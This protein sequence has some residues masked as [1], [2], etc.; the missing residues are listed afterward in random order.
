[1]IYIWSAYLTIPLWKASN[2]YEGKKIWPILVKLSTVF[3]LAY[4]PLEEIIWYFRRGT[5][6]PWWL[7]KDFI[8][9]HEEL[10][11]FYELFS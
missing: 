5:D 8:E 10:I 3:Y 11:T 7:Y 2:K 1:M 4:E 9:F 6:T